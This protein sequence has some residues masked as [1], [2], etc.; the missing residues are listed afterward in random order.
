MNKDIYYCLNLNFPHT[1]DI[2]M[3][4]TGYKR[5]YILSNLS[6]RLKL[7]MQQSIDWRMKAEAKKVK[8]NYKILNKTVVH[9]NAVISVTIK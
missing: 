6:Y 1:H 5:M 2:Y 7:V 4:Y 9:L 3:K 8:K